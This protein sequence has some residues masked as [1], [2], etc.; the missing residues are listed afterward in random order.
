MKAKGVDHINGDSLDN[1]KENLRVVAHKH[2]TQNFGVRYDNK[3]GYRGVS[4]ST[5]RKKWCAYV[6]LNGVNK[7]LGRYDHVEEAAKA[8]K[9][10]RRV[11]MPFSNEERTSAKA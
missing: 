3:S 8:V 9:A 2:N 5:S 6:R 11:M 7:N 4:W 1:R 10:Y